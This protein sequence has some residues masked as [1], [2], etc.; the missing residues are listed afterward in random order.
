[1]VET[2]AD[3][4]LAWDG[5]ADRVG[6]IDERGR[7]HEATSSSSSSPATSWGATRGR[8]SSST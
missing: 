8:R 7:R 2:G 4:G 6:V 1:V 5:D 3:L